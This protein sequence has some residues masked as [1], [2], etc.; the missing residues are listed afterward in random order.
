MRLVY[1]TYLNK[2][3]GKT[4]LR[5]SLLKFIGGIFLIVGTSIGGGM[6][7]LPIA[8]ASSGFINTSLFLVFCWAAMLLGAL[9]M[10][11]VNLWLP[12][13]ANLIS[14]ADKTLG[15]PGKVITWLS[16]LLLLYTLLS[17]YIAGGSDVFQSLLLLI[18]VE[19]PNS[20]T[21]AVYV[22]CFAAII[23]NGIHTV[24]IVNSFLM[25]AKVTVYLLL[26]VLIAPHVSSKHLI[27]G[28][29]K[30][31]G[32][33]IMVL[34]TS[35]GFAIIIPSLRDYFNDDVEALRRVI[36]IGSLFPL[37]CYAAWV[38]VIMGVVP[39][40]GHD[41]LDELMHSTHATSG[42]SMALEH[43]I[44]K[45]TITNFFRFFSSISMLT[46]FLGVSLCLFDFLADGLNLKKKGRQGL[47]NTGLVFIPPLIAV[48]LSPGI[49]IQAISYAG[50]L[51]V[52]LLLLLPTT[53]AYYGRYQLKITGPYTAPGGKV[54]IAMMFM[55]SFYVLT[56][57]L[58]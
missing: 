4:P 10:L 13:G 22:I 6:L 40:V 57:S 15:L 34:I 30:Y 20:I 27:G 56:A 3:L 12:K 49:Y 37:V 17:A 46:A 55:F 5:T 29:I 39:R 35:Y 41:S 16:Y 8:T 36:I 26:L 32:G 31:I 25:Y 23:Y 1:T 47:V 7:A 11:E 24:D 53:M 50:L 19:L 42:L 58:F 48:L 28:D 38:G 43:A 44:H 33:A 52:I 18:N 54:T 51:C 21:T 45:T 14:M 9:F 2:A